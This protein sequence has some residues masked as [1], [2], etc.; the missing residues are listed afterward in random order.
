MSCAD[1]VSV[2][3]GKLIK[4]TIATK[5]M[6]ISVLFF[7]NVAINISSFQLSFTRVLLSVS[8]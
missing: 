4:Q 1:A 7:V 6:P 3:L 8:N 2:N 5:I